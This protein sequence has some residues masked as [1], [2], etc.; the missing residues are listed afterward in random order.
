MTLILNSCGKT[1]DSG[2]CRFSD[3]R[4]SF[5]GR[6]G[7]VTAVD[8]EAAI[9]QVWVTFNNNR[10]SYQFRQEDV[11]HETRSKSMYEMWWVVR[12]PSKF[13][14]QKK[15]SFNITSPPC[16]FDLTNN[17]Y[18][19]YAIIDPRTGLPLENAYFG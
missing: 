6:V 8:N 13:T 19:P 3:T 1:L 11:M 4:F 12:S 18:F 14:V 9:P 5:I 16:T 15:K 2:K 10:T 7:I 17:R